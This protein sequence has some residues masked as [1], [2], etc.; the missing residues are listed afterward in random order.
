MNKSVVLLLLVVLIT[1]NAI[2]AQQIQ[3]FEI[4]PSDVNIGIGGTALLKC[5]VSSRH[6]D[7]QWIHDGTALGYDRKVPGKPRYSVIFTEN[8]DTEYHLQIENV[9][10]EDEGLYSC[11]AAPIGD[12]DTKL[13][14]KAKLNVLVGPRHGPE[15]MF[16][17]ESKNS[18]EIV[19]FRLGSLKTTKF[20]CILRKSKPAG[21]IKWFL[22]GTLVTSTLGKITDTKQ[23][24]GLREDLISV[25]ELKQQTNQVYNN[26]IIK[27]QAYHL[28]FGISTELANMSIFLRVI[29]VCK[30][31]FFFYKIKFKCNK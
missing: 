30:F 4:R 19:H 31:F 1:Q 17:D 2:T 13:E 11:Q 6:G 29:V 16:N 12:W 24:D 5:S 9:T 15:M 3:R 22:N 7:V 18:G 20:T 26:S 8:E 14:A 21:I 27:C 10:I 28:A 25:F 23:T